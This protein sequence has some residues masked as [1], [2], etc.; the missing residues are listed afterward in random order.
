MAPAHDHHSHQSTFKFIASKQF[1]LLCF[2]F[3][4][5]SNKS[6][7]SAPRRAVRPRACQF[8]A[9]G[10]SATPA[11]AR[12]DPSLTANKTNSTLYLKPKTTT[13]C[14]LHYLGFL[15]YFILLPPRSDGTW[16]HHI[17]HVEN[18][19]LT[20]AITTQLGCLTRDFAWSA[21]CQR[22]IPTAPHGLVLFDFLGA[23][24]L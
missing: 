6:L 13:Y 2:H 4:Y 17:A 20:T 14:S 18:R 7:E 16:Q 1:R 10:H 22:N 8:A 15:F 3:I 12:S 9:S 19:Q 11:P 21:Y 5:F 23:S 24:E